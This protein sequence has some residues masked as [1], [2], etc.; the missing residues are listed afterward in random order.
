ME[1]GGANRAAAAAFG[2]FVLVA[3]GCLALIAADAAV[4]RRV[5][6]WYLA[7]PQTNYVELVRVDEFRTSLKVG[8][9]RAHM[10]IMM[11]QHAFFG[12]LVAWLVCCWWPARGRRPDATPARGG[13]GLALGLCALAGS[14]IL[15]YALACFISVPGSAGVCALYAKEGVIDLGHALGFLLAAGLLWLAAWRFARGKRHLPG[16]GYIALGAALAGAAAFVVGMEEISWGQTYLA[17]QSPEFFMTYN[18]QQETNAHNFLNGYLTP[19]YYA[20]GATILL[21]TIA[22]FVLDDLFGERLPWLRA[23]CPPRALLWVALW[24]P[25]GAEIFIFSSTETFE[26]LLTIY[27]LGYGVA[28]LARSAAACRDAVTEDGRPPAIGQTA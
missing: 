23:L 15:A 14:A 3:L 26:T 22:A 19:I 20:M 7:L 28:I 27:A 13:T 8:S 5:N 18:D 10:M 2:L 12:A 11:A 21:G 6:A 1:G 16:N 24:F 4:F 17:W 25:L 9:F